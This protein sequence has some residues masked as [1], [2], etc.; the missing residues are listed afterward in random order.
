MSS[1]TLS[2]LNDDPSLID[3]LSDEEA[4]RLFDESNT[5]GATGK[6]PQMLAVRILTPSSSWAATVWE[7]INTESEQV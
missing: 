2:D 3:I 1:I 4:Q 6:I 5:A 7:T